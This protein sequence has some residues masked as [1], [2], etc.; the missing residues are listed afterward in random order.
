MGYVRG[1]LH[2]TA[3]GIV[4]GLCL[5]PQTGKKTRAQLNELGRHARD[6]YQAAERTF[7]KVAP[8]IPALPRKTRVSH[9]GSGLADE[10]LVTPS[11]V[12]IHE[13]L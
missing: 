1:L 12:H 11:N 13:E 4:V 5:A 7:H 6:T 3:A 9:N 8:M 2:G 10:P